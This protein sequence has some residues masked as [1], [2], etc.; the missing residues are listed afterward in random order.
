M[1]SSKS[2]GG[3]GYEVLKNLKLGVDK[4]NVKEY[5]PGDPIS[6]LTKQQVEDFLIEG[7]IGK[8]GSFKKQ[9]AEVELLGQSGGTN[10]EDVLDLVKNLRNE[11]QILKQEN[12]GLREAAAKK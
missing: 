11:I 10:V 8:S 9:Q 5:V 4:Q 1:A 7:V 2:N 12:K 6:G 3:G